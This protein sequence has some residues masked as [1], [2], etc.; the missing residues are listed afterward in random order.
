[1]AQ[2]QSVGDRASSHPLLLVSAS[3][4]L[5]CS[6]SVFLFSLRDYEDAECRFV[7]ALQTSRTVRSIPRIAA[8]RDGT[9]MSPSQP[10]STRSPTP[11]ALVFHPSSS[12]PPFVLV[13]C[14]YT[15]MDLPFSQ[16]MLRKVRWKRKQEGTKKEKKNR[17]LISFFFPFFSPFAPNK[18][19][20]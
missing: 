10:L 7:R 6:S 14:I 8:R 2:A 13:V 12:L 15:C 3:L 20:R 19:K 9:V 18:P 11:N 4:S 5:L 16:S 1:M 17:V